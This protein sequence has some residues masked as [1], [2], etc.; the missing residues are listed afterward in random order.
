MT[1]AGYP[2]SRAPDLAGLPLGAERGSGAA[3]ALI[4]YRGGLLRSQVRFFDN[5]VQ[6]AQAVTSGEG[7]SRLREPGPGRGRV[8]AQSGQ[9]RV[10]RV[11]RAR[12]ARAAGPWLAAGHGDQVQPLGTGQRARRRAQA[13]ARQTNCSRCSA[14]AA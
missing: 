12:P 7:R 5:G 3:N 11:Q 6:A 8:I 2:S 14:T 10:L 1:S 13:P 9:P 4:G